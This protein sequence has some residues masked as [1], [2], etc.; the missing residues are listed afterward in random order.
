MTR[1]L[2][3]AVLAAVA[4]ATIA[5]GS[6]VAAEETPAP[7]RLNWSFHGPFG[8]YDKAQ[9]QRGFKVFREVCSAC[10][11]LARVPFR[12][13][14]GESGLGYTEEQVKALAAEYQITDGPDENGEMFERPGRPSDHF[15][16]PF[17]NEQAA[18]AA[19]GG[20]APPDLSLIAKAR[21]VE[22]GFPWFI[23]DIFTQYQ[24]QGPDYIHALLTGYEE[25]PADVTPPRPGL[26]YNP[27]FISGSWIAMPP[28]LSDGAVAYEDGSP[29][30]VDQY[31]TDVAAFLMWAAEPKLE[32][33][34]RIG[35]EVAVYL[36]LFAGLMYFT[37]RRIWRDVHA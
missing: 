17:P 1:T 7:E 29:E 18:A 6:A 30:T 8:T 21:A 25:P 35:F 26:N 28:P 13:L 31:A 32:E 11:S 27:H 15:P 34:K 23:F 12:A 19:N 24:E 5:F 14:E 20:T 9:L 33:R 4:A 10:H 37:K 22:R 2:V 36:I 16:P 3:P